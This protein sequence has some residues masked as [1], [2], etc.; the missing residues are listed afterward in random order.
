MPE[1]GKNNPDLSMTSAET[2][3]A[4]FREEPQRWGLRGDPFLWREMRSQFE[5]TPLPAT[6]DELKDLLETAFETLTGQ[7]ISAAHPFFVER[8]S[9]GG[10]SSGYLSPD[11][12]RDAAI[13]L[14]CARYAEMRGASRQ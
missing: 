3:A 14:L 2:V 4:L 6:A 9:H 8:F 11:F 7:P 13:P 5:Q 10:M 1:P 12:W